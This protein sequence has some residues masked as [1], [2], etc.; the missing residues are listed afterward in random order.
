MQSL[1]DNPREVVEMAL[2][3]EEDGR[4]VLLDAKDES[5][6]PLSI[7]TFDFL[8]DQE[9]EHMKNIRAYAKS[10]NG[11]EEFDLTELGPGIVSKEAGEQ[12]KSIF[13]KLKPEFEQASREIGR[14]GVYDSALDMER[15]GYEFYK[16]ASEKSSDKT[17]KRIYGFLSGEEIKHFQ[18]IQDTRDFLKQPDAFMAIDE[19]W[20][21]F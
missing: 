15:Y 13:E 9:L 2:Q 10:L 5:N 3:L 8:A 1:S 7:A 21:T 14:L 6:D 4:R 12:I 19:H 20:M 16:A 18:I 11:E 17:A